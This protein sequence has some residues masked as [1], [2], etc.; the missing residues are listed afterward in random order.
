MVPAPYPAYAQVA[1]ATWL[2]TGYDRD[3]GALS[4]WPGSHKFCRP[5]TSRETTG[6]ERF[7]PVT[8]P[9]GSLVV[10]HGNTWNGAFPRRTPGL[11]VNLLV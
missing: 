9:A 7:V 2:L 4:F 6:V 1:N 5:A 3:A 10:W 8:A 11:R